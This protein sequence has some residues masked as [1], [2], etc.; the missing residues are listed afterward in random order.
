MTLH[1]GGEYDERI[2]HVI[3][4]N[5]SR[6][7]L[8]ISQSGVTGDGYWVFCSCRRDPRASQQNVSTASYS[9]WLGLQSDSP[10]YQLHAKTSLGTD[11]ALLFSSSHMHMENERNLQ[12]ILSSRDVSI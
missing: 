10:G 3:A 1:D 4:G 12:P 5:S 9:P 8:A 6:R 7:T 2:L 11:F